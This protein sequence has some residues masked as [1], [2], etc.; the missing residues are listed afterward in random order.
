MR[1]RLDIRRRPIGA[2]VA[3]LALL[4]LGAATAAAQ[5]GPDPNEVRQELE[6]TDVFLE[7]AAEIVLRSGN[8]RALDALQAARNA[9]QLAKG[10]LHAGRLRMAMSQTLM[11]RDLAKRAVA[12]ARQQGDLELRAQRGLEDAERT[13]ERARQCTG[14][15]PSEQARRLLD[16]ARSRLEQAREAFHVLKFRVAFDLAMQARRLAE[17]VCGGTPGHAVEQLLEDVARLLERAAPEIK[18]S[19]DPQAIAMLQRARDL[20]ERAR[21]LHD[22]HQFEMAAHHARQ[23]RDL[24]LRALRSTERP[25]DAAQVERALEDATHDIEDVAQEIRATGNAEAATLVERAMHHLERARRLLHDGRARAALAEIRVARN[26]AWRAAQ[27][28]GIGRP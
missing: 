23:A 21:S 24:V 6:R 4:V 13:L 3:V 28:A 27:L 20:F 11:A 25:P 16:L 2:V 26:L 19:G 10:H 15:P 22:A 1:S 7:R 18:D 9:Q 14:D 17:E 12:F 8:P 5:I